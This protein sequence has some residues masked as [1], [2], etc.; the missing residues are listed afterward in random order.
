VEYCLE[1]TKPSPSEFAKLRA[2]VGWDETDF[3]MA[4]TSLE[5]SLF[6]V[7][8]RIDTKLV[9]MGRIIGDGSMFF[10]IQDLVVDPEYHNLGIGNGLMLEIESYLSKVAKKGSTIGLLSAVG[11]ETFYARYDYLKRTGSPFGCGMC[12]FI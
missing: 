5:N 12:K 9:G 4:K 8:A 2:K 11:K 1:N 3:Q 10:Y 7:T 6:H